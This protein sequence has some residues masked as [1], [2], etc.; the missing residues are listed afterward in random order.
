MKKKQHNDSLR[1]GLSYYS[2]LLL[3]YLKESHPD[4]A[5]N[6]AFIKLRADEA[7]E[8][9]SETIRNGGTHPQAEETAN[10]V[11][12]R[13]LYFSPYNCLVNILWNEFSAQIPEEKAREVALQ[14]L[15]IF[16]NVLAQYTLTDDFA[17]TPSFD[18]FYTELTGIIQILLD[19][20]TL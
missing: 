17:D 3:S 6:I 9:Y 5:E 15:P 16:G 12:H 18:L 19:D 14:V 11:L 13:G 10:R 2:L 4:K 7:A 8:V 20:G 1:I